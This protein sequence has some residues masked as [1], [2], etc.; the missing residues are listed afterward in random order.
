MSD[1]AFP[2]SHRSIQSLLRE[3]ALRLKC[4]SEESRHEA[5]ILLSFVLGRERWY[6]YS[7]REKEVSPGAAEKYLEAV[8]LR[9]AGCPVAYITGKKEFY[10]LEFSVDSRVLIPRP[11][12][13]LI[14]D[15]VRSWWSEQTP[16]PGRNIRVL[17]LGTGSGALAVTLARLFPSMTVWALDCEEKALQVARE[18]ARIHGVGE[19][20]YFRKGVFLEALLGEQVKFDVVVS[21]PPYLTDVEMEDLQEDI[22]KFEPEQAL[23]GGVDGLDAYRGMVRDLP[24]RLA[25]PSLVVLEV[26]PTVADSVS[27]LSRNYLRPLECTLR[28]DYSGKP[29]VLKMLF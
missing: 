7:H 9:E 28:E 18:N 13:E 19:R 21:N 23:R 16:G 27:F 11:E 25:S 8:K 14:I 3:G 5:E 26:S 22:K 10:G 17:D 12:T 6:L 29:R 15:E 1:P 20:V 24:S 4:R 2:S